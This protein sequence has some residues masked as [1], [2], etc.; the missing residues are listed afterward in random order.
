[1]ESHLEQMNALL[2][3]QAGNAIAKLIQHAL[4]VLA[5]NV[6]GAGCI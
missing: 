2:N 6:L 4:L 5:A 1:M 3:G